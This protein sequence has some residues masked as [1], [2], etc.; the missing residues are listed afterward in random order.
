VLRNTL[1]R[2]IQI[3][4]QCTLYGSYGETA[5]HFVS[6]V[7][8]I[9]KSGQTIFSLI[10]CTCA[11]VIISTTTNAAESSYQ[12]RPV[13][14]ILDELQQGGL[15]LV[16]S[17]GL[18]SDTLLVVKPPVSRDPVQQ[19]IEILAPYGLTLNEVDGIYLVVRQVNPPDANETAS[20][21]I[22]I[23]NIDAI[24]APDMITINTIPAMPGAELLRPGV[25]Q[26]SRIEPGNCLVQIAAVGYTT[27]QQS[28]E[29]KAYQTQVLRVNLE[30][31]PMELEKLSVTASRYILFSNSQFFIDQRAIQALPD[32]GE[33]PIRSVQ[34][35]PGAA[36]NGLSSQSHFRGGEHNETA[37][38]LN[39]LKLMDPFHIRNYHNMFSSIDARAISG[40]EAYT[41]GFPANYGDH[42][43]G[44][45]LLDTQQPEKPRRTELG[46]S[47]YNTSL[48][49]SGYT[50]EARVDWLV[51]A[52]RSNLDLILNRD[53]GKPQYFD[54]F[55]QLGINI[56]DDTRLS[57][58]AMYADDQVIVITESDPD[59]LERS[60]SNAWNKH[61][62][63]LLENQW[64]PSLSS[65]TVVSYSALNNRQLAE[66]NDPEKLLGAVSDQ[67]K[68]EVYG[69]R[70]DWLYDAHN[71]HSL[72]G[73]FEI[74][75]EKARYA[76]S[77]R[78][79]YREF[80]EFYPGIENP[81][82]SDIKAAPEG[83][84][85][86]IYLSDRWRVTPATAIELGM[87]WDRQTYTDPN[88]DDQWSPR[89]SLLHSVNSATELRLT[90]GRYYQSQA[91]Q[92]LQ[93]EDGL[94][95]FFAPQRVNHWIAGAQF[96]FPNHYRLRIE[97]FL[98]D[99]DRLKPRFENLFDSLA[100]VPELQPD[101][102]RLDPES[103]RARGV[104]LTLEYRGGEA[105]NWWATYS[106]AKAT[107]KINGVNERR[108]WDQRHA[109]QAGVAWRRGPWETGLA[110]SVHTG[111]PIT[112]LA[113][114]MIPGE[115][116]DE[117]YEY[118]P[119]PGPR[120]AEQ[121][122]TFASFDFRISREYPV[123]T[124]RL[125]AFFEVTNATNRKNQC[126]IDYD[127]D[128]DDE[129]NVFLDRTVDHWLPI[130]PAI[131]ILWEF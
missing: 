25:Y 71:N 78:A 107:D 64:T 58:N 22:I 92:Q 59:E 70:Q 26:F 20:L 119:I 45:L 43:S 54:V 122:G 104:E 30:P 85:Y 39:G 120:N 46:L 115:D 56:S 60:K 97:A 111:W 81:T 101:R 76:Y 18:V 126:C 67:R 69:L 98:K 17:T 52:R 68:A 37:I 73:G 88:F 74:L 106:W 77:S 32:L 89:A 57:V 100:L 63:L 94:D 121:L 113:L 82:E 114:G 103:A 36:A 127:I 4:R 95:H 48:L 61:F 65:N 110:I 55:G 44:V 117:E 123:K 86:A 87:R 7:S 3:V 1:Y 21:L 128:D 2:W 108:S 10:V 34:R 91:I 83:N 15:P 24:P 19:V 16:Y 5:G 42:M 40:V 130:I 116:D 90:W 27:L 14:E 8:S 75:H 112:E 35:L 53:L 49:S 99:Y 33:D 125:S 105:L 79:E 109:L 11:L 13:H 80:F 129:G 50:E 38:F 93:V 84:A 29:L 41:G 66:V 47:I 12:G 72:R 96:L 124:G 62:W 6:R 131:G 9:G 31:G 102:V 118:F 51:S 28:V 23:T